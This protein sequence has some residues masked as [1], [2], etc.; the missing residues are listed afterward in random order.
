VAGR[1]TDAKARKALAD[2]L[3]GVIAQR[4]PPQ[5]NIALLAIAELGTAAQEAVPLLTSVAME[6]ECPAHARVAL[7]KIAP[8]VDTG[9]LQPKSGV[10][11]DLED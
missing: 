7:A 2:A 8:H 1:T 10:T 3:A 11:L 4:R 9:K 5:M 6:K